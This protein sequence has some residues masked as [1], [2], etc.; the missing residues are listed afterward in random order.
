[1][2]DKKLFNGR[3]GKTPEEMAHKIAMM[4][5]GDT[6]PKRMSMAAYEEKI[7]KLEAVLTS[8]IESYIYK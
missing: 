3:T 1:M 8:A 2:S 5:A 4:I 6:C 7:R